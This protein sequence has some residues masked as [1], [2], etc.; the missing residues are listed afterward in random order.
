MA[1][2][3]MDNTPAVDVTA[4][5]VENKAPVS[6]T[7]WLWVYQVDDRHPDAVAFVGEEGARYLAPEPRG[8]RTFK[9]GLYKVEV[10]A[11]AMV[12]VPL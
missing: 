5:P 2:P 8:K 7:F 10:P 11:S 1:K 9:R 6:H 3:Q 4:Q 12:D